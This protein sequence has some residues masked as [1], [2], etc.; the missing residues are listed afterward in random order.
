M[1][2][3]SDEDRIDH[4]GNPVKSTRKKMSENEISGKDHSA[5]TLAKAPTKAPI[6]KIPA[7]VDVR[8]VGN[9]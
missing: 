8:M 2:D 9:A 5:L 7:I 4:R 6:Q 1:Q 3:K